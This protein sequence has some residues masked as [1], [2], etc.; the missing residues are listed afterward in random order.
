MKMIITEYPLKPSEPKSD[1]EEAKRL[2]VYANNVKKKKPY[3][4]RGSRRTLRMTTHAILLAEGKL[5]IK[6]TRQ[7]NKQKR[8][9]N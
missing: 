1:I 2:L 6:Y 4:T 9:K 5:D 8:S 7:H 3:S